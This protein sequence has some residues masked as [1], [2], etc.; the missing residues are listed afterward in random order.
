MTTA[1]D[2]TWSARAD[3][4]QVSLDH[5]FGTGEPQLL[6][7]TYPCERGDNKAFNYWWLAHVIDVRLDAYDFAHLVEEL[8][9][10]VGGKA[11]DLVFVAVM[12]ETDKLGE[13]GIENP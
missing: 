7:N 11:H 3:V 9:F 8:W 6:N 1:W 2:A 12:R 13:G 4:A 5:F 10:T